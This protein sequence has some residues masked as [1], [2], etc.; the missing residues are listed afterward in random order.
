[1]PIA[2][3]TDQRVGKRVAYCRKQSKLTQQELAD[4]IQMSVQQVQKYEYGKTSLSV[5]MLY[6]ISIAL[7]VSMGN[8]LSEVTDEPTALITGYEVKHYHRFS[9]L[10]ER[11][12]DLVRELI[13][14]L[15]NERDE[16]G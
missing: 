5:G 4:L 16:H 9:R 8:L 1:M 7:N 11:Q 12:K 3:I 2:K 10:P 13:A 15:T 6:K 14:E